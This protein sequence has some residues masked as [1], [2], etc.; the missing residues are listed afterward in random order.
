MRREH[1]EVDITWYHAGPQFWPFS[2]WHKQDCLYAY[3]VPPYTALVPYVGEAIYSTVAQRRDGHE[4]DEVNNK[5][6]TYF[7]IE[8]FNVLVGLPTRKDGGIITSALI[9]DLESTLIYYL[10][11]IAN[12]AKK[13]SIN[14]AYPMTI[15]C[16]GAWPFMQTRLCHDGKV[17]SEPLP[18]NVLSAFTR[19]R[20]AGANLNPLSVLFGPRPFALSPRPAFLERLATPAPARSLPPGPD[21][22]FRLSDLFRAAEALRDPE[23]FS[24]MSLFS[25][26]KSNK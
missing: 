18:D 24:L 16:T 5:V 13:K 2:L 14:V 19:A 12:T 1:I 4:K 11:P 3:Q 7:G 22:E 10:Q 20:I 25:D 8:D 26:F 9:H 15:N 6:R 17:V 21:N 23:T